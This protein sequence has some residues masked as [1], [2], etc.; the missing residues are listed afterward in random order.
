MEFSGRFNVDLPTEKTGNNRMASLKLQTEGRGWV[1]WQEYT[2]VYAC[3]EEACFRNVMLRDI[4]CLVWLIPYL[5]QEMAVTFK[6]FTKSNRN[7]Q[8]RSKLSQRVKHSSNATIEL[9]Y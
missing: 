5:K 4:E 9:R 2:C 7:W 1:P 8:L 6:A 3:E